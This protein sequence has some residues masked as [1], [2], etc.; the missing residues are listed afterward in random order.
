MATLLADI[1]A[2]NEDQKMQLANA[3]ASFSVSGKT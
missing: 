1:M 3:R 2:K